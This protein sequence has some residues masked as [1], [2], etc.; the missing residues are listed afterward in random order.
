M[1]QSNRYS[2]RG[3]KQS[4]FKNVEV[5]F[6]NGTT[7]IDVGENADISWDHCHGVAPSTG[8]KVNS[9][10]MSPITEKTTLVKKGNGQVTSYDSDELEVFA[11]QF[12]K[13]RGGNVTFSGAS[14]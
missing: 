13:S 10:L 4:Q 8:R 3:Q 11:I 9:L 5:T 1:Q 14:A 6:A 7:T 12:L 2:S